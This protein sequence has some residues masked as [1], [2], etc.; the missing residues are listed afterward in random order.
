MLLIVCGDI[1]SNPGP[2][3]D[4]RVRV[5]YNI[6]GLH[7]NLGELAA[8]VSGY[9]VL[10]CV[11]SKVSDRRHLSELHIPG[12]GCHQQRLM[13]STPGAQGMTLN[14]RKDSAPFG[15]TSWSVVVMS[16]VSFVSAIV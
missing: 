1:E 8:T 3:S 12:F 9:N 10:V 2:S 13:N 11:E 16:L 5:L 6:R 15:R 7:E 14:V 4:R